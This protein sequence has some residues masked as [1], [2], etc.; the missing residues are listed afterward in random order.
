VLAPGGEGALLLWDDEARREVHGVL[1]QQGG[2]VVP[3]ELVFGL[4]A[5]A[6]AAAYDGGFLVAWRG[7]LVGSPAAVWRFFDLDGGLGGQPSGITAN[8]GATI[9]RVAVG[10]WGGATWVVWSELRPDGGGEVVGTRPSGW[11]RRSTCLG[12]SS[13]RRPGARV[14][15][16]RWSPM[17]AGC[18]CS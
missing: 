4:G 12:G 13:P 9:G 17:T 11:A 2:A 5:N 6:A 16:R 7:S 14:V 10:A 15:S 8:S 1:V 3:R 18:W